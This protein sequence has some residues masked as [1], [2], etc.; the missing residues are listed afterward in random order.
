MTEK[1]DHN[2]HIKDGYSPLRTLLMQVLRKYGDYAPGTASGD[3]I[4]LLMDLA[5]TVIDEVR[6]NPYWDGTR[7]DYYV[8]ADDVR[9]VPDNIVKAGVSYYYAAQQNSSKTQLLAQ[10]F[11]RTMNRELW[12]RLNGNT[13]ISLIPTDGGSNPAY[14]RNS[15]TNRN[16]GQVS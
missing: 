15:T 10:E 5:N 2:P 16:N 13:R 8:A 7:L 3:T 6:A 4:L 12:Y 9:P 1:S 11:L 14:S